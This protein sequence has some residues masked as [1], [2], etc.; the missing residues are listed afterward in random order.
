MG[1]QANVP[2]EHYVLF[3]YFAN[4]KEHVADAK[5]HFVGNDWYLAIYQLGLISVYPRGSF[6]STECLLGILLIDS[7]MCL[8]LMNVLEKCF[9]GDSASVILSK[10]LGQIC[11][12][13]CECVFHLCD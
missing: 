11:V 4:W 7:A 8:P 6:V 5:D 9:F 10:D 1:T 2:F 13:V 12:S 3:G